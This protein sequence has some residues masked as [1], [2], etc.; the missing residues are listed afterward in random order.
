M[1]MYGDVFN[2]PPIDIVYN[3]TSMREGFNKLNLLIPPLELGRFTGKDFDI[4]YADYIMNNDVV[5]MQFF[6]IIWH[7]Y[8]GHDVYILISKDDWAENLTES[9]MKL[10]QQ[11]YGING[12][13]INS[14]EDLFYYSNKGIVSDFVPSLLPN[15]DID[16][17]RFAMIIE[18]NKVT[19]YGY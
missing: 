9:L 8:L 1:L 14:E 13:E 19:N 4:A 12:I 16:K 17:D 2:L 7:L 5:F 15:L 10:I 6:D 3:L 11:R 18:S